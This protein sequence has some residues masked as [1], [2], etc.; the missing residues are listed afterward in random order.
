[1]TWMYRIQPSAKHPAFIKL[2]RQLAGGP[3]RP[4]TPNRLRWNP[5]SIPDEPTDFIDG[6]IG[7]VANSGAQKP[8]GISIYNYCANTSMQRVFFNADGELLL[9]PEQG[10]LRI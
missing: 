2:E 5:L 7:M 1:R 4:V 8:S 6:L 9:V 3:L 10:R